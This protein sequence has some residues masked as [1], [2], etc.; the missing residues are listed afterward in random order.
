VKLLPRVSLSE[1]RREANLKY[2]LKR[3][4]FHPDGRLKARLGDKPKRAY[5]LEWHK[6][7]F[8]DP[9]VLAQFLTTRDIILSYARYHEEFRKKHITF[10][11]MALYNRFML[12]PNRKHFWLAVKGVNLHEEG[13]HSYSDGISTFFRITP[14]VSLERLRGMILKH[15]LRIEHC[16]TDNSSRLP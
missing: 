3:N 15:T 14:N 6:K 1:I 5:T 2:G 16:P 7:R 11:D 12:L 8:K 9:L 4:L 10:I 13:L